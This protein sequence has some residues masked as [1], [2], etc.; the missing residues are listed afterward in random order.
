MKES[1]YQTTA[2]VNIGPRMIMTPTM[3]RWEGPNKTSGSLPT[4]VDSMVRLAIQ[5]GNADSYALIIKDASPKITTTE[6]AHHLQT[7]DNYQVTPDIYILTDE[8]QRQVA[9]KIADRTHLEPDIVFSILAGSGYGEQRQGL[10]IFT[11]AT[12]L[13]RHSDTPM[14]TF[15]DDL[16]APRNVRTL[17]R[18]ALS[19]V[20]HK[21]NTY[22]LVPGDPLPGHMFTTEPNSLNP[23]FTYLGKTIREI[24]Q[25]TPDLPAH[26]LWRDTMHSTL[27]ELN[28]VPREFIV[29]HD[30]ISEPI[31]DGHIIFAATATKVRHPDYRTRVLARRQL[32]KGFSNDDSNPVHAYKSGDSEVFATTKPDTNI[33]SAVFARTI[34]ERTATLPWWLVTS[35]EVSLANPTHLVNGPY[36]GDNELLP[37][38]PKIAERQGSSVAYVAGV[39]TQLIHTRAETGHRPNLLEQTTASLVGQAVAAIASERIEFDMQGN[40]VLNLEGENL[41]PETHIKHIYGNIYDFAEI[42]LSKIKEIALRKPVTE[43]EQTN[44]QAVNQRY[45]STYET[46]KQKLADFDYD[47]FAIH[48]RNEIEKQL[49]FFGKVLKATP[50]VMQEVQTMIK[51]GEYPV[52]AYAPLADR[53]KNY[54]LPT[55]RDSFSTI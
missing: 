47:T 19:G 15:D 28:G 29:T 8:L 34:N 11:H 3:N 45:K 5:D 49:A 24:R 10:D 46:I 9:Q 48:L 14:V 35:T 12:G 50:I 22:T 2:R 52:L 51:R 31:P 54:P 55:R 16:I 21:P 33:D 26:Q 42:C 13:L 20:T 27:E 38:M 18:D 36:R 4:M 40:P 23:L 37:A 53:N 39:P 17:R 6:R 25:E 7:L 44:L 43:S 1:I 32:L 41:V 30:N